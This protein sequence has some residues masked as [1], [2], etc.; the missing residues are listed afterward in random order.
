MFYC[1]MNF[2]QIRCHP[3]ALQND[4]NPKNAKEIVH[5]PMYGCVF[6]PCVYMLSGCVGDYNRQ[7]ELQAITEESLWLQQPELYY[8]KGLWLSKSQPIIPNAAHSCL[9]NVKDINI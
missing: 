1:R 2:R 7:E 4:R 3:L 5:S 8:L 6:D 9:L